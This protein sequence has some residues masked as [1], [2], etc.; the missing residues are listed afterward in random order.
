MEPMYASNE[1]LSERYNDTCPLCR[2]KITQ[3]YHVDIPEGFKPAFGKRRGNT[4]R[5]IEHD[6]KYFRLI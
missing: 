3:M 6:I 4:L 5:S 2:D 1:I